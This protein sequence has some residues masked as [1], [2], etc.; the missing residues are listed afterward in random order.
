VVTAVSVGFALSTL[1]ITWSRGG[2]LAAYK[3]T[4]VT[5]R[6]S[7]ACFASFLLL[8]IGFFSKFGG[9]VAPNLRRHSWAMAV[10]VTANAVSYFVLSTHH[11][12][13]A[14]ILLPAVSMAALGFWIF[15]FRK[16]GE[17][18]PVTP[19]DPARWAVADAMNEQLVKLADSLTLSSRGVKKKQGW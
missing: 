19:P 15:A 3:M 13:M 4:A 12:K 10:F 8:T 18:Q 14:N 1:P 7:S 16:S 17:A 11:Y 5:N 2:W 6:V 9:P